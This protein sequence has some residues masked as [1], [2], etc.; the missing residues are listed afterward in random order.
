MDTV[1]MCSLK[2]NKQK[3]PKNPRTHKN[4]QLTVFKDNPLDSNSPHK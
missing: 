4:K 3:L 2:A 1:N